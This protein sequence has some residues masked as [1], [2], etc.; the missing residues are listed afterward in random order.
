MLL[1]ADASVRRLKGPGRPLQSAADRRAVLLALGCVDEVVEFEED[2][3]IR[4]L[5]QLRPA[6]FVKGA[7]YAVDDLPEAPVMARWGGQAVVVPY[8]DG[9]STTRLV[10]EVMTRGR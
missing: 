7:D 8:L 2:T 4:A 5:E 10:Q 3:P 9:R 1:N 6:I